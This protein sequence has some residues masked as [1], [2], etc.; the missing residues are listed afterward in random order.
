M[1]LL[2]SVVTENIHTPTMEGIS[3]M[4]PSSPEIPFFEQKISP[5]PSELSTSILSSPIPSG[6]VVSTR[7]CVG[8]KV[9]T[10]NT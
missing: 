6:K 5:H 9:N 8:V 1:D 4:L 3:C 7:K 2:T 10:P